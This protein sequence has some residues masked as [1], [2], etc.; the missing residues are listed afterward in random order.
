MDVMSV[1]VMERERI[2]GVEGTYDIPNGNLINTAESI[3][4]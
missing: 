2:K 3:V 4:Q 1:S